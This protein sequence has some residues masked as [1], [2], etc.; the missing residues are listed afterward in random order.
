MIEFEVTFPRPTMY[1]AWVQ[2]QRQG[3]VNTVHFDIEAATAPS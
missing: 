2:F 3:I 1:R